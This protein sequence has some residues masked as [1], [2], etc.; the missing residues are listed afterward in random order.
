MDAVVTPAM[1]CMKVGRMV[2]ASVSLL[3]EATSHAV[4]H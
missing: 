3:D 4:L 1:N 2:G